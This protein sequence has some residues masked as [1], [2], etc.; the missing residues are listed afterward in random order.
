MI[1]LICFDLDGVLSNSKILHYESLNRALNEIDGKYVITHEEHEAKYD[2][3]PTRKKL[4]MLVESKGLPVEHIEY[5]FNRKQEFTAELIPQVLKRDYD[6]ITMM[7]LLREKGY[8]IAV[9][10]NI[11]KNNL[12]LILD[13]LEL[14][15]WIGYIVSNEDVEYPKPHPEMYLKAM[16]FYD[17]TP[18]ET[19]IIED[20]DIG[21]EAAEASGAYVFRVSSPEFVRFSTIK[22]QIDEYEYSSTMRR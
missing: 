14:S 20:S 8:M 16:K 15:P 1:K 18:S 12:H 22:Y 5:I 10:S 21:V 13:T 17:V 7:K 3:L 6:K 4:H 11:I 9:C 19:I 2:A